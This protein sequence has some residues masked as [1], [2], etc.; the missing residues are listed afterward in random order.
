LGVVSRLRG[1]Q[2]YSL[3]NECSPCAL[4]YLVQ[5]HYVLYCYQRFKRGL[6]GVYYMFCRFHTAGI[7]EYQLRTWQTGNEPLEV[8]MRWLQ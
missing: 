3:F 5:D 4:Q 6:V 1:Y 8:E 2:Q 7:Y